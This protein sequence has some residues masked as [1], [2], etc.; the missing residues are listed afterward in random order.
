VHASATETQR[1]W[2]R[3]VKVGNAISAHEKYTLEH[4]YSAKGVFLLEL[5]EGKED[6]LGD[7][8]PDLGT[9]LHALIGIG[10]TDTMMLQVL[11]GGERLPLYQLYG[12]QEYG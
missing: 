5:A 3:S 4:R 1:R 8:L 2:P 9:S 10:T 11:V 7:T 12:T 6:D